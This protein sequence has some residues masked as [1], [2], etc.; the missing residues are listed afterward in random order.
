MLATRTLHLCVRVRLIDTASLVLMLA[1]Q[2]MVSLITNSVQRALRW[3]GELFV[4]GC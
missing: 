1:A 4:Q 2:R 3:V